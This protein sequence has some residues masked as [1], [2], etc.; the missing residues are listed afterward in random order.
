MSKGKRV[1]SPPVKE[2]TLHCLKSILYGGGRVYS[3]AVEGLPLEL[4]WGY[5]F[6]SGG[7]TLLLADKGDFRYNAH[8]FYA[9]IA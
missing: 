4:Q 2:Y 6:L 5:S 1:Y 7:A 8:P 9:M 3:F